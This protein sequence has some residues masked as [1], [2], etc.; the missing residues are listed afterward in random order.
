MAGYIGGARSVTL[1]TTV[2]TAQDITAT[3]TT[4][5]V[6]IINNPHEDSDSGPAGTVIF[7]GQQ[8]GGDERT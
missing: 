7:Q 5:E 6:T 2:A 8:A 3:D 4:P 1:S